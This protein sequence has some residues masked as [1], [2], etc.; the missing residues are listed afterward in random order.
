[1]FSAQILLLF[2]VFSFFLTEEDVW[3]EWFSRRLLLLQYLLFFFLEIKIIKFAVFFFPNVA[4]VTLLKWLYAKNILIVAAQPHFC[5][6]L[7]IH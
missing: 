2:D 3:R 6:V 7:H 1:M 4:L 5:R